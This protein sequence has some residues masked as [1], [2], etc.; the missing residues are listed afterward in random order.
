MA[1]SFTLDGGHNAHAMRALA[2]ELAWQCTA[3][4]QQQQQQ[5][6]CLALIFA[7]GAARNA[8]ENIGLL[9]GG[10]WEHAPGTAVTVFTVP[11]ALPEGMPWVA[12]HA[13]EA[14]AAVVRQAA[15]AAAAVHAASGVVEALQHI[16]GDEVL[17]GQGACRAICGSLYL[18]SE[19]ARLCE[20]VAGP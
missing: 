9:L 4:A 2:L 10:L 6:P 12:A 20:F 19:V 15:P 7:C 5:Q 8:A 1:L 3:A 13:P 18:V 11:Y 17:R 16:A 14:L